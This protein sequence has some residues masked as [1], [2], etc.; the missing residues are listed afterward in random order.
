MQT[1]HTGGR[2]V[3]TTASVAANDT[4]SSSRPD[5]NSIHIIYGSNI[6]VSPGPDIKNDDTVSEDIATFTRHINQPQ[7]IGAVNFLANQQNNNGVVF[8]AALQGNMA[9]QNKL[10]CD[11]QKQDQKHPNNPCYKCYY[12]YWLHVDEI[13]PSLCGKHV[14]V[15]NQCQY[16]A[17]P[18]PPCHNC[19]AELGFVYRCDVCEQC[20]E[21]LD[22]CEDKCPDDEVCLSTGCAK[23]CNNFD[24][25]ATCDSMS[26]MECV[27]GFCQYKCTSGEACFF[28]ICINQGCVPECNPLNCER[29]EKISDTEYECQS[30]L[31]ED[32]ECCNGKGVPKRT[33]CYSYD[34]N[35]DLV[36]ICPPGTVCDVDRC[37][38]TCNDN[39]DCGPC[40]QCDK[41]FGSNAKVCINNCRDTQICKD[42]IC[43]ENTLECE[44]CD[45][46]TFDPAKCNPNVD[47]NFMNVNCYSCKDSCREAAERENRPIA[48]LPDPNNPNSWYCQIYE[49]RITSFNGLFLP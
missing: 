5:T 6:V 43:V 2:I 9:A 27:N 3:S 29:C 25:E 19:D 13:N 47:S 37:V 1:F 22:A 46:P 49:V 7:T 33:E 14:A 32:Q 38:P 18:K 24:P 41:L 36:D 35:C 4:S 40:Q 12:G 45:V 11:G 15:G 23:K 44:K 34:S 17:H 42:G 8:A 10:P 30:I 28:G 16:V 26:C 39:S 20:N 21:Q 48:C 31:T